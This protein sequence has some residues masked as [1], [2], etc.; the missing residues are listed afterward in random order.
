M[1]GVLDAASYANKATGVSAI[2][3]R[4]LFGVSSSGRGPAA[5][6]QARALSFHR[7]WSAGKHRPGL[8]RRV[9]IDCRMIQTSATWVAEILRSHSLAGDDPPVVR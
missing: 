6:F 2:A 3:Q 5:L 1:R 9:T 8:S 4:S 7:A